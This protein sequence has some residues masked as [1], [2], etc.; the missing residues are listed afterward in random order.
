MRRKSDRTAGEPVVSTTQDCMPVDSRPMTE[1]ERRRRRPQHRRHS[2]RL[3][4]NCHLRC[5]SYKDDKTSICSSHFRG[6]NFCRTHRLRDA[7]MGR[8]LL[9]ES[10]LVLRS[11][12]VCAPAI[13]SRNSPPNEDH[14]R[15]GLRARGTLRCKLCDRELAMGT[16]TSFGRRMVFLS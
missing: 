4:T 2:P 3:N 11:A 14:N 1:L 6:R 9:S 7:F 13:R 15:C 5:V 8:N 10:V 12:C 16:G